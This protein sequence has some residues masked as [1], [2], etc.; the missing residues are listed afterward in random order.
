[1]HL[2]RPCYNWFIIKNTPL[3]HINVHLSPQRL[4]SLCGPGFPIKPLYVHN[5]RCDPGIQHNL[6]SLTLEYSTWSQHRLAGADTL[7]SHRPNLTANKSRC[8][9]LSYPCCQ[10]SNIS[11]IIKLSFRQQVRWITKYNIYQCKIHVST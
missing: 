3:L 10:I 7:P 1:M 4:S 2:T 6:S 5:T 9:Q 11:K 8:R